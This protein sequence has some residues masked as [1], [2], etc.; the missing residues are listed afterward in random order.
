MKKNILIL[1]IIALALNG[2]GSTPQAKV[3]Y[4]SPI[5]H[6]QTPTVSK[7]PLFQKRMIEVAKSTLND[8][9]Y[10]KMALNTTEKKAWFRTLMYRLWDRQITRD[11]FIAT[12]LRK[13]PNKRYEFTFV[14]NGFQK[15]S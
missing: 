13:Y 2:C 8:T 7:T 9:H 1:S 11:E 6:Y 14:A 10:E 15:R 4:T 3:V 5:R 12:G